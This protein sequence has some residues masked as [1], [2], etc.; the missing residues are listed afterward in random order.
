[1]AQQNDTGGVRPAFNGGHVMIDEA[2]L[3]QLTAEP[4]ARHWTVR[5]I[6][7][8]RATYRIAAAHNN[9]KVLSQTWEKYTGTNRT[10]GQIR[11]KAQDIGLQGEE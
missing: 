5:E 6:A 2:L 10:L 11:A 4:R 8:L 9:I 3:S 1:M 7:H